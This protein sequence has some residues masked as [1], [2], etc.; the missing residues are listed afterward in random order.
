VFQDTDGDA[1]FHVRIDT[2]AGAYRAVA[3]GSAG[4]CVQGITSPEN[5]ALL[6]RDL[7][8][9]DKLYAAFI[10]AACKG[11]TDAIASIRKIVSHRTT[12]RAAA[13]LPDS[14]VPNIIKH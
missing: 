1:H 3:H 4:T 13:G 2:P 5:A 11:D 9:L 12:L 8:R 7:D 6:A 14:P 10:E